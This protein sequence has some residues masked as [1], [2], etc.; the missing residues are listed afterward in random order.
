MTHFISE[1]S[2]DKKIIEKIILISDLCE[3]PK[4]LTTNLFLIRKII[5]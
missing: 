2:Y 1:M 3:M 5:E 4:Y